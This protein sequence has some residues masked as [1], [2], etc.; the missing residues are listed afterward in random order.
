MGKIIISENV[1]LDGVV[2][3]PTG[4]E[5]FSCGGW[6]GQ[7]GNKD[8]EEWAKVELDEAL[9]ADALLLGRRTYEFFAARWPSRGGR[10]ADRLNSMPKYVVSA[11]LQDPDW[12]NTTVL[13]GDVAEAVSTLRRKVNGDIVVYASFQLVPTLLEHGLVD[14]LRLMIY[15]FVLGAGQRLFAE[16]VPKNHMRLV[17]TRTVGDGLAFLTYQP[18]PIHEG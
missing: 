2:Q 15:P 8:R 3:D 12:K 16:T 1:T 17:D 11:T 4:D 7:V 10:W 13:K 14:E 18:E 9:G 6:F 5:G